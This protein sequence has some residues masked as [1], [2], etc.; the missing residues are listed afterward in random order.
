MFYAIFNTRRL[1]QQL[2]VIFC[3]CLP[4]AKPAVA[5]EVCSG[6]G[7]YV[8]FDG[9]KWIPIS[10]DQVY[11]GIPR[12]NNDFQ[13]QIISGVFTVDTRD[14]AACKKSIQ[15][16]LSYIESYA[17]QVFARLDPNA[18]AYC[19]SGQAV[20]D[21]AVFKQ[22]VKTSYCEVNENGM[23]MTGYVYV[24]RVAWKCC[25]PANCQQ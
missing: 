15:R 13:N 10:D 2:L 20:K 16:N 18:I 21:A 1:I 19:T 4:F 6:K 24:V 22:H 23:H 17:Q 12:D 11:V 9:T 3:C 5:L 14:A 25:A 7:L 8:Y